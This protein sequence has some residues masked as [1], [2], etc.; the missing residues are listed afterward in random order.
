MLHFKRVFL[1]EIHISLKI[2]GCHLL[3]FSFNLV[4]L[5]SFPVIIF[6]RMVLYG[7]V[8]GIGAYH[9]EDWKE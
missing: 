8:S 9:T 3:S 6:P 7:A 2:Y 5:I 1:K 4:H